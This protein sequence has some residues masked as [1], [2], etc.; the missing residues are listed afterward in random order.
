MIAKAGGETLTL[1]GLDQMIKAELKKAQSEYEQKLYEIREQAVDQFLIESSLKA[2]LAKTSY[3]Q[4]PELITAEVFSKVKEPSEEA[5]LAFYNDNK[6]RI[7]EADYETV[8]PQIKS[9]IGEQ[10]RRDALQSYFSIAKKE[11]N[12]TSLLEP[13]RVKVE[14]IGFSKGPKNAPITIVEF[15]DYECGFCSQ[16]GETLS[17]V[18][19]KYPGKVRLVFRDF[20]LNFHPNAIP[21]AIAARCAGAQGK[22][23]EMHDRL[24][25][26]QQTLNPDQYIKLAGE[27]ALDLERFKACSDDPKQRR[28]VEGDLNAGAAV[29]VSGTPAFFVNGIALSGAQPVERFVTLIERELSRK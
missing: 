9:Y 27:L 10:L 28:A 16:A 1:N 12:A 13:P 19:E 21:A 20:P 6:E 7:G 11:A 23:W 26:N 17:K 2:R 18:M 8:K 3:S 5:C 29:G 22:F 14:A 4:I 25:Q 15:A 24:F